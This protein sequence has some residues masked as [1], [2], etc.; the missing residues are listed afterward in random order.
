MKIFLFLIMLGILG[1]FLLTRLAISQE[2]V[3]WGMLGIGAGVP[4]AGC[5]DYVITLSSATTA[6]TCGDGTNWV[7]VGSAI[8]PSNN[9]KIKSI[10]FNMYNDTTSDTLTMRWRVGN[11]DLST[12]I[13]ALTS[14]TLTHNNYAWVDFDVTDTDVLTSDTIYVGLE[15]SAAGYG[16]LK[17]VYTENGSAAE[18][19]RQSGTAS[20]WNMNGT[21]NAIRDI[22]LRYTICY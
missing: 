3:A 20:S 2:Q 11:A 18:S 9:G 8:T 13:D 17:P 21:D 10:G 7:H 22:N 19:G 6:W 15:V 5:S 12:Y 1:I 16:H 14:S 4:A